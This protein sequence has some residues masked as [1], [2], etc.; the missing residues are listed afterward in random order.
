MAYASRNLLLVPQARM[1]TKALSAH[2][3][4][5]M[6]LQRGRALKGFSEILAKWVGAFPIVDDGLHQT[7]L[8]LLPYVRP[9]L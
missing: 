3:S 4:I 5:S 1:V 2:L 8:V 7:M 6:R 9:L